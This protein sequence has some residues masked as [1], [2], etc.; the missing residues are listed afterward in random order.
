MVTSIGRYMLYADIQMVP[1]GKI[2]RFRD[3]SIDVNYILNYGP[4]VTCSH[5]VDRRHS[6]AR[7][8]VNHVMI[9]GNMGRF[10]RVASIY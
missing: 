3:T 5:L 7:Q 4:V 1:I 10:T 2:R 6:S 8:H 9:N